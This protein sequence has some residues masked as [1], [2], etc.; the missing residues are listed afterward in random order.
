MQRRLGKRDGEFAQVSEAQQA[1]G[2]GVYECKAGDELG[3]DRWQGAAAAEDDLS[4]SAGAVGPLD[5]VAVPWMQAEGC[6]MAESHVEHAAVRRGTALEGDFGRKVHQ[7][8]VSGKTCR[9][10]WRIIPCMPKWSTKCLL[11]RWRGCILT[12]RDVGNAARHCVDATLLLGTSQ[13]GLATLGWSEDHPRSTECLL[14]TWLSRIS[15]S[16]DVDNAVHHCV[17]PMLPRRVAHW[18][19]SCRCWLFWYPHS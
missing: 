5:E 4:A 2:N 15:T 12:S 11:H 14:R 18:V 19:A 10:G 17:D 8:P 1:F 6:C 7:G 3:T 9:A 16:R 13:S